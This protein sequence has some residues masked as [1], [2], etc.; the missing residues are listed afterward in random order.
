[1]FGKTVSLNTCASGVTVT[2]KLSADA[3]CTTRY[4]ALGG[5]EAAS[6]SRIHGTLSG[7]VADETY[8]FTDM[9]A[10]SYTPV[11]AVADASGS[12]QLDFTSNGLENAGTLMVSTTSQYLTVGSAQLVQ[13]D[14]CPPMWTSWPSRPTATDVNAD[15]LSDIVAIDYTGRLLYFQNSS[16][17]SSTGVPFTSSQTIGS[18][19][20]PQFG[21][22][23]EATGDLTG[24]QYA[25]IVAVRSDGALVAYY[26]N[27]NSNPGRLPYSSGT[28]IGSGWQAFTSITFGDVNDDGFADL[29]A[30]KS[31][32]TVWLYLNR[33]LSNPGHLPFSSGVPLTIPGLAATDS[34]VTAD[35]N[36]DGFAD[37][38]SNGGWSSV[39][40]TPA[41]SPQMFIDDMG[42]QS[43]VLSSLSA[44]VARAGW[45]AGWYNYWTNDTGVVIAN[46][47]GD[48]TLL[49][50]QG[51]MGPSW[52]ATTRVIGDGWQNI[53]TVLS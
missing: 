33:I 37:V 12:V 13:A 11:S 53:R 40:R 10:P 4:V 35:V 23:L 47:N 41:G 45:A 38:V 9:Y 48:G 1:M 44:S 26:N 6:T 17:V 43:G 36:V 7:F 28:V 30:R 34:F 5:Q 21:F 20:G 14:P 27:M 24:D 32:G 50:L 16:W 39:N 51:L 15:G 29:I 2:G 18:G 31:D 46:P 52:A 8:T 25:E 42:P 49:Y 19:W 22:R 3:I